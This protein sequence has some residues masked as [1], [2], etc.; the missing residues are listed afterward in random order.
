M[1]GMDILMIDDEEWLSLT[2]VLHACTA[3]AD[4]MNYAN[5]PAMRPP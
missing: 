5:A 4:L 3:Y 2:I 1:R